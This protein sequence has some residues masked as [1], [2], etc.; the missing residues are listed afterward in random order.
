MA[1]LSE[2]ELMDAINAA[3]KR[4]EGKDAD[5]EVVRISNAMRTPSDRYWAAV[6]M[7][8]MAVADGQQDW[9]PVW[10]LGSAQEALKLTEEDMDRAFASAKLFPIR[11]RKN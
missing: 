9:R 7:M 5:R 10:L 11:Q 8:I 6:Y 3:F 4:V 1:V 2:N